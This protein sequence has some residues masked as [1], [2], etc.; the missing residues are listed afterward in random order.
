M[1]VK[2][3]LVSMLRRSSGGGSKNPL[4]FRYT[5]LLKGDMSKL[6]KSLLHVWEMEIVRYTLYSL[7]GVIQ[8]IEIS[9]L[10]CVGVIVLHNGNI[11]INI[12]RG[13]VSY[14][15]SS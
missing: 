10:Q 13:Y 8:G 9:K 3:M 1:K 4:V 2:K 7:Y 11:L 14:V 15:S 12:C 6:G 5:S